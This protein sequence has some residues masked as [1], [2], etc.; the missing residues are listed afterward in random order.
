MDKDKPTQ[1]GRALQQLD[2]ELIAAYSP[3]ASRAHVRDLAETPAPG[4]QA[5]R[6]RDGR[7][8]PLLRE[9]YLPLHNARFAT[10]AED[11]GSAFGPS[12]ARSILCVQQERTV[13]NDNTVRYH[14]LSLQI[15]PAR[16]RH[17]Y[18]KARVRVHECPDGT[19]A[20]F[21]GPRCLARYN[22]DGEPILIRTQPAGALWTSGQPLRAR[23]L[24]Q[25]HRSGQL[26]WYINRS[27]QNVLDTRVVPEA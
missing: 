13:G 20:L 23:P 1:V 11:K 15:P 19:L 9:L 6:H 21:H 14:G 12:Q 5:R 7:G 27:T 2:I 26:I 4:T 25:P 24:A 3:E 22:A 18:V 16:H 8:Q 17:H 10:P